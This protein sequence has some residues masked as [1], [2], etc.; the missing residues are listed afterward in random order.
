LPA[1]VHN[2]SASQTPLGIDFATPARN[3]TRRTRVFT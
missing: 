2:L 3:R 1:G